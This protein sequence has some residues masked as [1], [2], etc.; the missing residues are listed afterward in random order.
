M[1]SDL[2]TLA[3]SPNYFW[4]ACGCEDSIKLY[5]YKSQKV[6]SSI[7]M[8]PLE[9]RQEVIDEDE[10]LV[11]KNKKEKKVKEAPKIGVLSLCMNTQGNMLYAGCTDNVVRVYEIK[12]QE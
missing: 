3:F 8:E 4:V 12:E 7:K 5:D 1:D 10:E 11:E 6:F 2:N 9:M